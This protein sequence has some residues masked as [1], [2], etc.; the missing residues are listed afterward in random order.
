MIEQ[1]YI[2][3]N[4]IKKDICYLLH[5]NNADP[6]EFAAQKEYLRKQGYLVVTMIEGKKEMEQGLREVVRNHF[7]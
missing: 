3:V 4:V 2:E 7:H 1:L 5:K 6:K